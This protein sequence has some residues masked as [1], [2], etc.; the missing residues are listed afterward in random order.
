MYFIIDSRSF[1]NKYFLTNN[2]SNLLNMEEMCMFYSCQLMRIMLQ[3]KEMLAV[4]LK[5]DGRKE[6]LQ[7][8][9][10][11]FAYVQCQETDTIAY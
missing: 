6:V 9:H 7:Y 1:K 11:V 3:Q 10:D 8:L 4:A 5:R 2:Q